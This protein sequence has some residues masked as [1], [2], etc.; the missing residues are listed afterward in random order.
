M[1]R[2]VYFV[3]ASTG[4]TAEALGHSL[5]SQFETVKFEEVCMPLVNT[6]QRAIA[7]TERMR[8][9]AERD[10]ARPICF[11]TMMNP[12]IRDI[13]KAGNCFYME[14]LDGFIDPLAM[15]LGVPPCRKAGLSH[16]ITEP[17]SYTKRMAAI[18]FAM[19][20]DDGMQSENYRRADL[21]L[22]GVSRVGKT[23]TCLYLAMHFGLN[24][25]NYPL[26]KE[27]FEKGNVSKRVKG[28]RHKV[29]GLT[30]EPQRL[31]LIREERLP[32]SEYASLK[33]CEDEVRRA[34]AIF[35]RMS[36]TVLDTTSK[37]IEEISSY[38]LHSLKVDMA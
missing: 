30:I 35:K 19:A 24:M 14:L 18:N 16:A 32:G 13:L 34:E 6:T 22:I 20:N 17:G 27:D 36:I 2:T 21:I 23:P 28:C 31:H 26:T 11:A 33:C 25:A 12:E 5:I 4:I 38:I 37:S 29:F 3:S 9:A 8:K 10:G 1:N 7:L 15:E